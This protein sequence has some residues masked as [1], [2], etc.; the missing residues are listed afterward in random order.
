[1]IKNYLFLSLFTVVSSVLYAQINQEHENYS[2]VYRS[3]SDL[4]CEGEGLEA[5][6]VE[7]YYISDENDASDTDGGSLPAGSITYR[8]YLD[9]ATD[10]TLET[11]F[12]SSI[13][14]L[15]FATTTEFF[16]NEDRGE[17]IGSE[18][19]QQH[20][21]S[22]T[23]ALDSYMTFGAASSDHLAVLKVL[24][25]DGSIVG[26][27]N[28]DGGSA[29]IAGGILSNDDPEAGIPLTTSDGL[30]SGTP[31]STVSVGDFSNLL[32]TNFGDI[33]SSG[34]FVSVDGAFAVLGG[35]GGSNAENQ[36]LI[37]QVTTDGVFSFELNFRLA[38]P[39]GGFEQYVHN[40]P[41]VILGTDGQLELTCDDL[42]Y[43]N[44][45]GTISSIDEYD[46][47]PVIG[48]YP[49]PSNG[50]SLQV[51]MDG[52]PSTNA[53]ILVSVNDIAGREV[54]KESFSQTADWSFQRI[55]FNNPL[56]SGLYIVTLTFDQFQVSRKFLV[57]D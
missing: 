53:P 44:D 37:A 6:I 3:G 2:A 30:I 25:T 41:G 36:L 26:G 56:Q 33:N 52:I 55:N 46:A 45:P 50:Q 51:T 40:N 34:P 35:L 54:L 16:N 12:G 29:A 28:S 47:S 22:N 7:K 4:P 27:V 49:N 57:E 39:D 20:L 15:T 11:I 18:I 31:S 32:S 23:V 21:G 10:Y 1:M 13:H 24:D 8:I 42:V 19:G 14:N 43:E 9:M 5:V 17:I 48:I 38:T